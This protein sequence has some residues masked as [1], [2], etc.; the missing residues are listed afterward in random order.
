MVL[1]VLECHQVGFMASTAAFGSCEQVAAGFESQKIHSD[2]ITTK[3][4]ASSG[5]HF[6]NMV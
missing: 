3:G 2:A 5:P 6:N 4:S 1:D